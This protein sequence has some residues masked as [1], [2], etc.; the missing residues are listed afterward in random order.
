MPPAADIPHSESRRATGRRSGTADRPVV[1]EL[2]LELLGPPAMIKI[3][4]DGNEGRV[5]E[6]MRALLQRLGKVGPAHAATLPMGAFGVNPI[7]RTGISEIDQCFVPLV[8]L[9]GPRDAPPPVLPFR[10]TSH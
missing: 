10:N 1:P 2:R 9:S 4:V 6:G 5:L 7:G 3:D 8:L